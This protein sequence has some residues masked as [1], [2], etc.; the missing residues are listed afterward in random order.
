MYREDST[1]AKTIQVSNLSPSCQFPVLHREI[2]SPHT[3]F[4]LV[5][6]DLQS[7]VRSP[8]LATRVYLIMLCHPSLMWFLVF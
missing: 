4:I 1:N 7:H 2:S 6:E 5:L 3:Q 8:L